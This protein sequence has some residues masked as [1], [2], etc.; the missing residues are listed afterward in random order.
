MS[1]NVTL[2]VVLALGTIGA[3]GLHS[4]ALGQI[5]ISIGTPAPP[6]QVVVQPSTPAY[7]YD[8]RYYRYDNP[9]WS[10]SER[11]DG[12]W[13]PVAVQRV[14]RP[15]LAIPRAYQ[16]MPPGHFAKVG[17]HPWCPP[18]QAKKGRC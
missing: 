14:P 8:G 12:T 9:V 5:N 1:R 6:P 13:G 4:P 11:H 3:L 7:F 10:S 17:P 2:A 18:G 15:V 16:R